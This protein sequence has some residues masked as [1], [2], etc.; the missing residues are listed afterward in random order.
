MKTT[1]KT[2]TK[3]GVKREL[4]TE[5]KEGM[6]ALAEARQ[7]SRTLRTQEIISKPARRSGRRK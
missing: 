1:V 5:L 2:K 6:A 7:G 4:F 3:R